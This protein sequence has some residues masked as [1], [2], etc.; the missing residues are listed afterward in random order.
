MMDRVITGHEWRPEAG[1]RVRAVGA[2]ALLLEVDDPAAWF[3]ELTRRRDAGELVVVD[4]V[5]GARTVLLDGLADPAA[6]AEL[7]RGW[8]APPSVVTGGREVEIP[9]VFDG[10][11]LADVAQ[12]WGVEPAEVAL[13]LA[14]TPLHVA[15][16]GFAPGFAYLAGLPEELAVPRL[17]TP[18]SRI[19]AGSVGL[20]DQ[21]AGIYPSA[22]PGGWRLVGR[23]DVTLFDPTRTPPALLVPGTRVRLVA[24]TESTGEEP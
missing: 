24:V 7:L 21:Y 19:A 13:R 4:I 15:F 3:A 1:M 12:R 22:S 11:D 5:P 6:A 9:V 14:G 17:P 20:A 2:D 18:R 23:T 16:C 8:S 10:P